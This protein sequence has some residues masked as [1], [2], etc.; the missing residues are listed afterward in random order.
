MI[1][2]L[3]LQDKAEFLALKKTVLDGLQHKDWFVDVPDNDVWITP[4]HDILYGK[5]DGQKLVGVSGML[6]DESFYFELRKALNLPT[7]KIAEMGV[8]LVLPDYRGQNIMY[9]INSVV[10]DKAREMGF[11]YIEA[12]AH[13]DNVASCTSIEKLGFEKKNCIMRKGR[14][15]RNVY[16][17]KL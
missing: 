16:L 7:E 15:L 9:Q 6:L 14:Y 4:Q 10:E 3:T 17:L 8:S 12:T 2:Q 5:F 13:P 11:E 1:R